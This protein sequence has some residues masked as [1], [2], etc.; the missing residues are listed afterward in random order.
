M[1][2]AKTKGGGPF[3]NACNS[4]RQHYGLHSE[5]LG[6]ILFL[7]HWTHQ[8]PL[9]YFLFPVVKTWGS[10][11]KPIVYAFMTL[12]Q[13]CV[14]PRVQ[15]CH[16][17]ALRLLGQL[18]CLKM[19]YFAFLSGESGGRICFVRA[20]FLPVP[21]TAPLGARLQLQ[22]VSVWNALPENSRLCCD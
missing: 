6:W 22:A 10:G 9:L 5:T 7:F 2:L 20:V 21:S 12:T 17:C 18:W 11:E 14:Y 13:I 16:L 3:M 4:S 8:L 19:A 1:F 15:L